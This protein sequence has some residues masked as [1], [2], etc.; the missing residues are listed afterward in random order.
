M[1]GWS[2]QFQSQNNPRGPKNIICIYKSTSSPHINVAF[3][4]H[5]QALRELAL[6]AVIIKY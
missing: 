4:V 2:L 6:C 3:D 1:R 5:Q